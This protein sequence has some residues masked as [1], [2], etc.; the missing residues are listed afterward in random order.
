M[1]YFVSFSRFLLWSILAAFAGLGTLA[2]A[3]YLYLTPGLPDAEQLKHTQLQVPLRVYTSDQKLVAEYGEKRRTPIHIENVP[4]QFKNAFIAAEDNQ[5]Y[6]HQGVSIKGLIRASLELVSTGSIQSG[7][8]TITMQVAKNFFLSRERTFT[9]KFNEILLAL[10]IEQELTKDEILE[11]YFN[12]IYFGNRAYGIEAAAQ[13]YYGKSIQEL[14]LGQMAMIAGLPKAPSS[15]NPLANASRA[16]IRRDW[17]LGRMHKLHFI[18]SEDYNEAIKQPI[19]ASYHGATPEV[20]APYLA[21]MARKYMTDS[22]GE[23]AYED[24]YKVTL[25][26]NSTLQ[27]AAQSAVR[28]GLESYDRRHGY[29]GPIATINEIETKS[30]S[31]ILSN[32]NTIPTIEALIPGAVLKVSDDIAEILLK[33]S[34]TGIIKIAESKWASPYLSVN[35]KGATP[36]TIT[37][38]V[39]PGDVIY[40]QISPEQTEEN[41]NDETKTAIYLKLAQLPQAQSALI[42]IRPF[43]GAVQ[44]LVGGYSFYQSKYNRAT[45]AKRQPGSNFKPFIYLSAL[46]NGATAATLI[47]DAPI[48]FDDDKLESIW[49]PENSSGKFLGETRLRK[50]LYQSKNLVSIRLLQDL[51]IKTALS[52]VA[53]FGFDT[54]ALPHDLS[55]ALG[56]GTLTPWDIASGY[57]ILANGGYKVKPYFIDRIENANEEI[58]FESTPELACMPCTPEKLAPY[59]LLHKFTPTPEAFSLA[60]SSPEVEDNT[61][62]AQEIIPTTSQS[63][64]ESEIQTPMYDIPSAQRITDPRATYILH[65]IMKDVIT[66]G[67]G[68]RALTLKRS[69]IAGKTGTTNDQKDAWFSGFNTELATSVWVGFDQPET[70]GRREYGAAAALP[71]WIDYMRIALAG[72][73]EHHLSQ[74]HGLSTVRIN[75]KT[76]KRAQAND[77]NAIFEIFRTENTPELDSTKPIPS[78]QEG[79]NTI[80]ITPEEIF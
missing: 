9:R 73:Q 61:T 25:T 68:R 6:E 39:K 22:Y 70:L 76:G 33:N 40:T 34:Q 38:I 20:E 51:G 36:N 12:K 37:D 78:H 77:T 13:A 54:N 59:S 18:S 24:G 47:N 15:Y 79:E 32:L 23:A 35:S 71:I 53:R 2:A 5:F 3:L 21:E 45:Q 4:E 10:Q 56:S 11:L 41:N 52:Y 75:P 49:R 8:S 55:L 27:Q 57:A 69:D 19:T 44:A 62:P 65:D 74:P 80:E 48:V 42:S 46:E 67:T 64:H 31:A 7:G 16:L 63:I 1:S 29:R 14:T 60:L 30:T 66:R 72:T 17:I 50:A 28:A 26:V 43:D 58:L